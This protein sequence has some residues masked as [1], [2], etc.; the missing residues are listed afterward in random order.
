MRK[1]TFMI[2]L[3]SFF[4]LSF[5]TITTHSN[6]TNK[7]TPPVPTVGTFLYS[8]NITTGA[9]S[10][11]DHKD[12]VVIQAEQAGMSIPFSTSSGG[13]QVGKPSISDFALNKLF[14]LSTNKI[15]KALLTGAHNDFEIRYYDGVSALPV[16]TIKIKDGF[17]TSYSESSTDCSGGCPLLNENFTIAAGTSI[18]WTYLNNGNPQTLIYNVATNTVN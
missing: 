10:T 18:T 1:S 12:E 14:D 2:L 4:C 17:L 15:Q 8:V 7:P 16:Y 11:L 9:G 5:T 6:K 13:S 3:A